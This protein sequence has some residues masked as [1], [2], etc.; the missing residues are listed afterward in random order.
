M[1]AHLLI[2][3]FL[4]FV[5]VTGSFAQTKEH[6][7]VFH[8]ATSDTLAQKALVKQVANVLEYW[9]TAKIEVVVHNNGINFMKQDEARFAKEIAALKQRGVVFAVCENTMKQRKIEKS[10]ILPSAVFV[11]VGLAEIVLRQEE[12]WSYIKA[13]F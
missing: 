1:K 9:N 12:G 11:P 2:F 10:Q 6:R 4:T 3:S 7:I 13:G 5:F 8:L